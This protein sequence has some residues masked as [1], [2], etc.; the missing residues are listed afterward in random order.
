MSKNL[1]ETC[2]QSGPRYWRIVGRKKIDR[3]SEKLA[4]KAGN[5]GVTEKK[6]EPTI[7]LN[8]RKGRETG[9]N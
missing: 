2:R 1:K 7:K 6:E 5:L 3:N 4:N 8:I 9:E